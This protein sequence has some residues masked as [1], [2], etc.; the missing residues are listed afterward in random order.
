MVTINFVELLL[1]SYTSQL[2]VWFAEDMLS[3][4]ALSQLLRKCWMRV[5]VHLKIYIYY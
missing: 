3:L 5:W 4:T 2:S 1:G